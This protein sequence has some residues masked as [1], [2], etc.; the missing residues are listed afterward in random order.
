MSCYVSS[1]AVYAHSM[2]ILYTSTVVGSDGRPRNFEKP[3]FASMCMS[4]GMVLAGVLDAMRHSA[5]APAAGSQ[6]QLG[7][8]AAWSGMRTSELACVA[9]FCLL[10]LG[11]F[12]L[13][14]IGFRFLPPGIWQMFRSLS[15]VATFVLAMLL[16][17]RVSKRQHRVGV[18][19]V[20]LGVLVAG[21][22]KVL[23]E[24]GKGSHSVHFALLGMLSVIVGAIFAALRDITEEFLTVDRSM[25]PLRFVGISGAIMLLM[26]VSILSP[27]AYLL[28]GNDNGHIEDI[29]ETFVLLFTAPCAG[30]LLAKA[31]LIVCLSALVNGLSILVT[32]NLSSTQNAMLGGVRSVMIYI[33]SVAAHYLVTDSYGE[34]WTRSSILMVVGLAAM[35][36]GNLVFAGVLRLPA[37]LDDYRALLS[38]PPLGEGSPEA[39][40]PKA[41]DS[42]SERCPSPTSSSSTTTPKCP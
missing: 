38:E 33:L 42:D 35:V 12:V 8:E 26:V 4:M 32:A 25:R 13:G 39:D 6:E 18:V 7:V 29:Y 15:I 5:D 16:L 40:V 9:S 28:P 3:I 17:K 24:A 27:A 41:G 14:A 19:L 10:D 34:A 20:V 23:D 37:A 21:F 22:A 36:A 1:A 11:Q 31:F 2:K 30:V